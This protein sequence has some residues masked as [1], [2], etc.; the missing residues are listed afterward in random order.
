MSFDLNTVKNA[1]S[2]LFD[3]NSTQ[4]NEANKYLEDFQISVILYGKV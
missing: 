4:Q 2:T 3:P 1:I